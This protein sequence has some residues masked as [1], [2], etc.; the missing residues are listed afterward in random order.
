MKYESNT[1]KLSQLVKYMSMK[2]M[3]LH[4]YGVYMT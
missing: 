1:Y 3:T 4:K 2:Y